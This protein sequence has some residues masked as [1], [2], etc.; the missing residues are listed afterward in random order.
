M[1]KITFILAMAFASITL[2]AQTIVSTTPENKNAVLEEFTGIHCT[3]CPDGHKVSNQIAAANVGDFFAINIH[4]GS[5]ATPQAGEPDFR[6]PWGDAIAGQ[7][8]LTGYP[9]GTINRHAF[10]GSTTAQGRGDWAASTTTTIGQASYVNIAATA[11]VNLQTR[12]VDILVEMYITDATTAPANLKLNVALLQNNLE[13]PQTGGST[14][15][16]QML[17][18]GNYNHMHML[19]D[20]ITGQW[21]EDIAITTGTAFYSK[22]YSYTAPADINSIPVELS[23]LE[24]V[25]FLTE[26][27]QE[28]VTGNEAV[29]TFVTPPGVDIC[30]LSVENMTTVPGICD[31]TITPS[32]KVKNNSTTI[33]ADTFNVKYSLNG[34]ADVVQTITAALAPGAEATFTFPAENITASNNEIVLNV[35]F[36]GVATKIDIPS[37]NNTT[38]TGIFNHMPSATIGTVYN[39]D[40]ESYA[41]FEGEI[42]NAIMSGEG[43]GSAFT[44]N[45]TEVGTTQELGAFGA[46]ATSYIYNYYGIQPNKT[47]SMMFHKMDFSSNTGYGLKFNYAYAQYSTENDKLDIRVSTDCG[48]TFTTVWTKQGADLATAPPKGDGNFFPAIDQWAS[49]DIDLSAYNNTADVI[50]EFLGTSAY[51]NNL[52]F[53]DIRVYNSTDVSIATPENNNTVSVYPNPA[54][55][56]FNLDIELAEKANVTYSVLNNLGQE[57]INADLGTLNAGS[58]NQKVNISELAQ[59]IYVIQININNSIITKKLTVN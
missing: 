24:I 33:T 49:A 59:G 9:S 53:D 58:Q 15:P 21:G 4:Q 38:S 6:T 51:G 41:A 2:F 22:T 55:D 20:L 30:D 54:V 7:T 23:D 27:Q 52:Y 56:Q 14:N 57:V 31:A 37:S 50:I 46:S 35:N 39:E 32:V 16:D 8:G 44:V 11:S 43:S 48:A 17:P 26:T 19:R 47:V 1:K 12:V 45:K 29:L 42:N 28:I 36:D 10:S 3:Y 40:F 13:G 18:N 34:G 5:Y 25:V